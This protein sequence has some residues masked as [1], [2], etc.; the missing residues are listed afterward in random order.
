MHWYAAVEQHD[1]F[2]NHERHVE[3]PQV[4]VRKHFAGVF[5]SKHFD[6]TPVGHEPVEDEKI[7]DVPE[8]EL[9][10]RP[11]ARVCRISAKKRAKRNQTARFVEV[12]P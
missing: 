8:T 1:F 7:V 4:A 9:F 3:C 12:C 6:R 5:A 2:D 10:Q 11:H